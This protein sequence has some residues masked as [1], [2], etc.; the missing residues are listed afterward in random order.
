[1]K[2]LIDTPLHW[3]TTFNPGATEED[4]VWQQERYQEM[5]EVLR[6]LNVYGSFIAGQ[7]QASI[8]IMVQKVTLDEFEMN[9]L[10]NTVLNELF[11]LEIIYTALGGCDF[12]LRLVRAT[13]LPE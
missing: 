8:D 12:S 13:A 9:R 2:L 7:T 1:M 10:F 5:V 6:R 4:L 11:E 3:S